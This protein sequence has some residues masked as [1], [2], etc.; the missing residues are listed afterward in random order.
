MVCKRGIKAIIFAAL[1][2]MCFQLN[3]GLTRDA[4]AVD[5]NSEA[6]FTKLLVNRVALSC[7]N[8]ALVDSY[9]IGTNGKVVLG[10]LMNDG[11]KKKSVFGDNVGFGIPSINDTYNKITE[12]LDGWRWANCYMTYFDDEVGAGTWNGSMSGLFTI[13]G[14]SK[15]PSNVSE[16][17]NFMRLLGYKKDDSIQNTYASSTKT[18]FTIRRKFGTTSQEA[19]LGKACINDSQS[20]NALKFTVDEP[21]AYTITT[22]NPTQDVHGANVSDSSKVIIT[23]TVEN[24][25]C[26]YTYLNSGRGSVSTGQCSF[27]ATLSSE[28][29]NISSDRI[30]LKSNGSGGNIQDSFY[31][32]ISKENDENQELYGA[33]YVKDSA[34]KSVAAIT[35]GE[36]S[37]ATPFTDTEKY[38]LYL[39]YLELKYGFNGIDASSCR[40]A[41]PSNV[42]NVD[43]KEYYIPTSSGWCLANLSLSTLNSKNV[44]E[45]FSDGQ[46]YVLNATEDTLAGIIERISKL[47]I[48]FNTATGIEIPTVDMDDPYVLS[49]EEAS[50]AAQDPCYTSSD[51][52]GWIICPVVKTATRAMLNMYDHIEEDFLVVESELTKSDSA[53]RSAWN[54]FVN[55]ANIAMVI[56]LL[57][58]IVSQITGAGIDNYG[59][60]KLLPK[61]IT[62]AI[63][64]N[65]SFIICQLA[66]DVSNIVG[67]S[68]K[69]LL[70]SISKETSL[71]NV[72]LCSGGSC[73]SSAGWFKVLVT[74]AGGGIVGLGGL[75]LVQGV[76]TNGMLD[77][78]IIP[79]LILILVAV[80]AVIFFFVLLGLRKAAIVILIV[81]SPLAFICYALPNTKKLFTKWFDAMKGLLLLYPLCGL[82]VGGGTLASKIILSASQDYVTYFIG[83]IIMVVPFFMIPSLLKSSFKALGG[84]GAKISGLGKSLR[85]R[86]RSR[87]DKVQKN[88]AGYKARQ[89]DFANRAKFRQERATDRRAKRAQRRLAGRSDLSEAQKNRLRYANDA[90]LARE[91]QLQENDIRVDTNYLVATRNQQQLDA[92]KQRQEIGIRASKDYVGATRNQQ[93]LAAEKQR[94]ENE[95]HAKDNYYN[96]MQAKQGLDIDHEDKVIGR[97]SDK[98]YVESQ[99]AALEADSRSKDVDA[100]LALLRN[101][102]N[103]NTLPGFETRLRALANK[104]SLSDSERTE[105][106]ALARGVVG[107]KGG[108]GVL[109]NM[110]RETEGNASSDAFRQALS[111][112]YSQ[113]ISV[114]SKLNEKD[115]GASIYLEALGSGGA[116]GNFASYASSDPASAYR[117]ALEKRVK[118]NAAGLNQSGAAFKEYLNSLASETPP[119]TGSEEFIKAKN[120]LQDVMNDATL[121]NSLDVK[122]REA[123][124]T[125]AAIYGVTGAEAQAVRIIHEQQPA[126]QTAPQTQPTQ[127]NNDATPP[128]N[129]TG[130]GGMD[131]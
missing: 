118:S 59:I 91:N 26:T 105:L 111:S 113:D 49:P 84:I 94:L 33:T 88:S 23:I 44:M 125:R 25:T 20:L 107:F 48:D 8:D 42:V 79:I 19:D 72:S 126:P 18:C 121:L 40:E 30:E 7:F 52:L 80:I 36:Y 95:R 103:V 13:Y 15:E 11:Y 27:S 92:E 37:D 116:T 82:V 119:A 69:D 130:D 43:A 5:F 32:A 57:V 65:L 31:I 115:A 34:A 109:A 3:L 28:L 4:S 39:K 66:V 12:T 41:K 54:Y 101:R 74:V 120:R 21:E 93:K 87:A 128:V 50:K 102:D 78:L 63:L 131:G 96:A 67:R 129:F 29:E 104:N 108:A 47:N 56:L 76:L 35:N 55:F 24:T 90:V 2:L 89:A 124:R 75:E 22:R 1:L 97:Y 58:V 9:T 17:D 51:S 81:I 38:Q 53:T 127:N 14:H 73:N 68:L 98:T 114:S 46:N 122:D 106:A 16:A 45:V 110:I 61:I 10:D 99:K 112:I 77:G 60:K 85:T 83:T 100:E 64:I 6:F 123:V 86:T 70:V 71:V 62:V 117:V